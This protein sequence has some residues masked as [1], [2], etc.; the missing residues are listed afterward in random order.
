ML[1]S[2]HIAI[3]WVLLGKTRSYNNLVYIQQKRTAA[4]SRQEWCRN[5]ERYFAVL[6]ALWQLNMAF[7]NSEVV[8]TQNVSTLLDSTVKKTL[9]RFNE[10]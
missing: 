3:D 2:T 4:S 1:P 9:V 6:R 10:G 7:L 5:A 8:P